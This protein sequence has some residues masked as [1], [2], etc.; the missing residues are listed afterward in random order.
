MLY[1]VCILEIV[2][3]IVLSLP[4]IAIEWGVHP[5]ELFTLLPLFHPFYNLLSINQTPASSYPSGHGF[6]D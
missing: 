6:I 3:Y 1:K 4:H 5:R 2:T